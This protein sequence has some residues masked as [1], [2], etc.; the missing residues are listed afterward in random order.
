M[1]DKNAIGDE[2]AKNT[3]FCEDGQVCATHELDRVSEV[4]N[5]DRFVIDLL[6][7]PGDLVLIGLDGELHPTKGADVLYDQ[8]QR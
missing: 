6:H 7:H 2:W 3:L 4:R 8:L 5:I 1:K